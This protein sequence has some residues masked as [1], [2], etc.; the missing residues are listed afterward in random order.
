MPSSPDEQPLD[1]EAARVLS[2]VRR[3]MAISV[4]FTGVAIA[5]V[6]VV[7]GYR[8]FRTGDVPSAAGEA[9][10]RL[11]AGA[12]VVSTVVTADRIVVTVETGGQTEVHLFDLHTLAQR[13]RLRITVAP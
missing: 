2:R 5:A 6:L 7:V 3:L 9:A 13:G 11:P 12:R 4:L 8:V 10:L 1:P